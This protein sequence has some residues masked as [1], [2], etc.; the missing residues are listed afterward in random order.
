[1]TSA[2]GT[3]LFSR[4][5]WTLHWNIMKPKE[6]V[7]QWETTIKCNVKTTKRAAQPKKGAD[8]IDCTWI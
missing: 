1:M 3:C 8:R 5:T 7:E 6:G 2:N 4:S